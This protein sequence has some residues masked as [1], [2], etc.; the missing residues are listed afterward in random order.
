[1]QHYF[2]SR[3]VVRL[4]EMTFDGT[5]WQLLRTKPDV[6]PLE[7]SQ[8]YVGTFAP[9]GDTIEGA[10]ETSDDL[11]ATWEHDFELIYR[12]AG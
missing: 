8:R 2:D 7:F 1:L 5:T 6:T 9:D 3:G 11:G 4:Y 12:R 10:W